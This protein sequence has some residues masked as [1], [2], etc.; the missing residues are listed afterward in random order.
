[1][2]GQKG[3]GEKRGKRGMA[4]KEYLGKG[5]GSSGFCRPSNHHRGVK[6]TKKR[7]LCRS[8]DSHKQRSWVSYAREA[9]QRAAVLTG[10]KGETACCLVRPRKKL[11]A[12]RAR[13]CEEKGGR[14][15][16]CKPRLYSY[17]NWR[18]PPRKACL[19]WAPRPGPKG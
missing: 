19:R 15:R 10:L 18:G 14:L 11:V 13:W 9:C 17:D 6:Q 3:G 4:P 7:P 16:R 8:I 12:G 5:S 2:G 1:M